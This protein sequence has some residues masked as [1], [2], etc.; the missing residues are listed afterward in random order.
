[1]T[2]LDA[3]F[4][5]LHDEYFVDLR[6][7][8]SQVIFRYD[9]DLLAR[10]LLK[11]AYNSARCAGSSIDALA[12]LRGYILGVV[13]RPARLALFAELLSPSRV[14]RTDDRATEEIVMPLVYRSAVTQ[15]TSPHGSRVHTRFIEVRSFLFHLVVPLQDTTRVEFRS[16]ARELAQLVKGVVKL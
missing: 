3:Y 6:D 16:A 7:F 8:G 14:P 9:Y 5:R 13:P 4:C 10:V 11:I 1:M 12:P 15:L 2:E